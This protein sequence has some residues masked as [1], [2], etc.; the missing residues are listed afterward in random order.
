[1]SGRV[2]ILWHNFATF[3]KNVPEYIDPS[4]HFVLSY[5][6]IKIFDWKLKNEL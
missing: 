1:M 2:D 4:G 6:S 5:R 3:L